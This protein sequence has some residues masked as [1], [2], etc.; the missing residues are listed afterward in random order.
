MLQCHRTRNILLFSLLVWSPSAGAATLGQPPTEKPTTPAKVFLR[1]E[2]REAIAHYLQPLL[3]G[4]PSKAQVAADELLERV[5]SGKTEPFYPAS[6]LHTDLAHNKGYI[7]T[8]DALRSVLHL[9]GDAIL[10]TDWEEL[11]F[12]PSTLEGSALIVIVHPTDA[13]TP[14][15]VNRIQAVARRR[16]ISISLVLTRADGPA[17]YDEMLKKGLFR[18]ASETSGFVADFSDTGRPAA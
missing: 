15:K 18:L 7:S 1:E 17:G 2:A 8:S 11:R 14:D 9:D 4:V 10:I 3:N 5:A 16:Q 6:A 12:L 13:I